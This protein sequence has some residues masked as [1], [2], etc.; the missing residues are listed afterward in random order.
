MKNMFSKTGRTLIIATIFCIALIIVRH[1][2]QDAAQAP[3]YYNKYP[4]FSF[5]IWNLFLAWIPYWIANFFPFSKNIILKILGLLAWLIFL[6]NAPYI[7]TDL[8]HLRPRAS[9]PIW[10]DLMTFVAFA[11]TGL[12]LGLLSLKIILRKLQFASPKWERLFSSICIGLCSY[13]VYIG[14]FQRWN[15]WDIISNPSAIIRENLQIISHPLAHQE[16]LGMVL[17]FS[18]LLW[19]SFEMMS[20]IN[21]H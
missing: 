16:I 7:I 5:L 2:N 3:L 19:I 6:P 15:S 21:Q 8:I 1:F 18:G 14:R 17:L 10:Y 4:H 13:G 11:G 20:A 9:A 12:M